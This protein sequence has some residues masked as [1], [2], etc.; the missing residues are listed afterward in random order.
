MEKWKDIPNFNYQISDCGR[1]RNSENGYILKQ[2]NNKR[3]YRVIRIKDK[4]G[5][6]SSFMVHRLVAAAFCK[7]DRNLV[8][9]N[10]KDGVKTNNHANN[11]EWCTRG[12]NIKHAWDNN[13]RQFTDNIRLAVVENLKKA[14]TPEVLAR[15][16]YP[17]SRKTLCV[18]TGQIFKSMRAA[19]EAVGA[20]E[21]NIQEACASRGRRTS[22]GFH[23]EYVNN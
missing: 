12:E 22:K 3:G 10:H 20:H 14:N 5:I 8:E 19:A 9:V 1:V 11:L 7:N 21:Q 15:K 17:R 18:E 23:W 4:N 6:K 13:L 2:Q 16:R